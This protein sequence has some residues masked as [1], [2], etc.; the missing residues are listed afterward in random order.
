MTQEGPENFGGTGHKL[1]SESLQIMTASVPTTDKDTAGQVKS[2]ERVRN[3]AEVFTAD[4]EVNAMLDLLGDSSYNIEYRYLEPACGNGNFTVSIL[5]RKMK[6][7]SEKYK[8]QRDFE[9]YSLMALS[10]VYGVDIDGDNVRE[11]RA[12]MRNVII[13]RFSDVQNSHQST[14]GFYKSTD[15]IL[16]NNIIKGDMIRGLSKIKF[17]EFSSPKIYKFQQRVFRLIDVLGATGSLWADSPNTI[18]EIPM[19]NYWELAGNV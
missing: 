18:L 13:D 17:T 11:A 10:S 12:R 14:E 15:Y 8:R 3:L 16:R 19:R 6:T 5:E 2:K 9:F 4:R 7:V 1:K